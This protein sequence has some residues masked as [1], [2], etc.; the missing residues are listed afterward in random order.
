M[1]IIRVVAMKLERE[2]TSGLRETTQTPEV[3]AAL[4]FSLIH[5]FYKY[6]ECGRKLRDMQ[7]IS[8]TLSDDID[9]LTRKRRSIM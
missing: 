6:G 2:P 9:G 5:A 4:T 8:A 3:A 7:G 1:L